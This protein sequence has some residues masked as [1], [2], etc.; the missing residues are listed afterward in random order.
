M[1]HVLGNL[2]ENKMSEIFDGKQF[3]RIR[4]SMMGKNDDYLL[5]R[6]CRN[7]RPITKKYLFDLLGSKIRSAIGL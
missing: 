2:M 5:C 4:E 6:T 1:K 7:A 3:R